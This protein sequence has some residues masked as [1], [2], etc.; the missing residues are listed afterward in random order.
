[1]PAKNWYYFTVFLNAVIQGRGKRWAE[2]TT[3]CNGW[4]FFGK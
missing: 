3:T 2:G 1:M 4:K